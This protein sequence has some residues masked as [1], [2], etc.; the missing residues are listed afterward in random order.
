MHF[1]F[2]L[3]Y[4]YFS[5]NFSAMK[6]K[7]KYALISFLISMTICLLIRTWMHEYEINKLKDQVSSLTMELDDLNST[8]ERR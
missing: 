6:E 1:H 8:I 2:L 5:L 7:Y 3:V 4:L